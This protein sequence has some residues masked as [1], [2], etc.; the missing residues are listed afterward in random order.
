[1]GFNFVATQIALVH[2]HVLM[3]SKY[4]FDFPCVEMVQVVAVTHRLDRSLKLNH[5]TAMKPVNYIFEL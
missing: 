1:M 3:L 5:V 2:I 4:F